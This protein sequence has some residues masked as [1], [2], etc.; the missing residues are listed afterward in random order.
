MAKAVLW[1]TRLRP[2][3]ASKAIDDGRLQIDQGFNELESRM[4]LA[5]SCAVF[6]KKM[7]GSAE[8]RA[9]S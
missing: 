8:K 5:R 9:I 1:Q 2:R 4:C 3:W 7:D 6:A